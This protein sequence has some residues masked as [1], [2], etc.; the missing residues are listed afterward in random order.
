MLTNILI[1]FSHISVLND[2]QFAFRVPDY[3][4]QG[5]GWFKSEDAIRNSQLVSPLNPKEI[6]P[7]LCIQQHF[8]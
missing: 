5:L 4:C 8:P 6:K 2:A 7:F 1:F 3:C